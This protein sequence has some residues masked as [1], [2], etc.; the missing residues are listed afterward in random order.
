MVACLKWRSYVWSVARLIHHEPILLNLTVSVQLLDRK[1]FDQT[2][3][4]NY[5]LITFEGYVRTENTAFDIYWIL[6]QANHRGEYIHDE[7]C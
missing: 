3:W 2:H 6:I 4:R 7:Y 5:F 1:L